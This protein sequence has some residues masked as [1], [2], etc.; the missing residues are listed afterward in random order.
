MTAKFDKFKE[1]LIALCE[2]HDVYIYS[3]W[4]EEAISVKDAT[5]G[6]Y[7]GKLN[8]A[9]KEPLARYPFRPSQT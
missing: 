2:E 1:A 4:I 6:G 3:D 9:T 7:A 5:D 8:D